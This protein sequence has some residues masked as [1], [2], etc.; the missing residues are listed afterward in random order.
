MALSACSSSEDDT[1][2]PTVDGAMTPVTDA[3]GQV[4]G[5]ERRF[6][7]DV[8]AITRLDVYDA[9]QVYQSFVLYAYDDKGLMTS[10]TYYRADG[11]AERRIAYTYDDSG[12]LYEK[13]L[14]LPNGEATVERLDAQG[15]VIEKQYFGTD[16]Q[17][18]YREVLEDG[19]WVR[20]DPTEAV[21]E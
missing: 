10:E 8:G 1:A 16:E 18:A 11:I 4:T 13:A 7:N 15:N 14:E 12:T 21:N 3:G 6:H 20:Y 19:E 5:Y 2:E 9:D 17:L